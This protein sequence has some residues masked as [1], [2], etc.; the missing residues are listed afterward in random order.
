MTNNSSQH[1]IARSSIADIILV[2][3]K[4][5]KMIIIT[6]IIIPLA[7]FVRHSP[8][9]IGLKS[10]GEDRTVEDKKTRHPILRDSL[11]NRQL[12]PGVFGFMVS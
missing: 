11:L 2:I 8:Q 10:Y 5:L 6:I 12:R 1:E 4:H 7:Q 9:R 3:A